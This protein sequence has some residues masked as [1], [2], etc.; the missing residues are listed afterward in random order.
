MTRPK[1]SVELVPASAWWSNVR[2]NVTAAEWETCKRYAKA[3]TG[4]LCILCG[5]K[6]TDQGWKWDVEAHEI[7]DY[8]EDTGVQTL[9]DIV[10]LCPWCHKCK[11]L[12]RSQM[13]MGENMYRRLV[14]HFRAVNEWSAER[15][16]TYFNLVFQIWALR[17]DMRWKLDVSF[18]ETLGIEVKESDRKLASRR[19]SPS[20]EAS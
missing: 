10:P 13:M 18:L 3:K 8:D 17:S 4:G 11:H 15:T 9:V 12:G 7:W 14:N 19:S 20:R 6:G 5:Q 16:Q 1:L 2:S